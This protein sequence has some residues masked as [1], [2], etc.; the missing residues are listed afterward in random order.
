M[1]EFQ[2]A[3]INFQEMPSSPKQLMGCMC[4]SH[5]TLTFTCF[6][7]RRFGNLMVTQPALV[8][9]PV[10][11]TG[12]LGDEGQACSNTTLPPTGWSRSP[13]GIFLFLTYLSCLRC[14]I[15]SV[16]CSSQRIPPKASTLIFRAT[17]KP[18]Q[19]T[20]RGQAST[21]P[22]FSNSVSNSAV[23]STL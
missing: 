4:S 5:Q 14:T 20:C 16:L 18:S 8:L 11:L 9:T 15:C 3:N 19:A 12:I 21:N 23:P 2:T 13:T 10:P 1:T 22:P 17:L 6:A 7:I